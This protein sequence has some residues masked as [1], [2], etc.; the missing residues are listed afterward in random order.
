MRIIFELREIHSAAN[1][2]TEIHSIAN[3]LLTFA[4]KPLFNYICYLSENFTMKPKLYSDG[5]FTADL[6]R[7]KAIQKNYETK[8]LI[9]DFNSRAE[10]R[11]NPE[12]D[13][14]EMLEIAEF[15]VY[16]VPYAGSD[17]M[18]AYYDE[19]VEV[20]SEYLKRNC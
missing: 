2:L 20:W 9:F 7:I 1:S 18:N 12:T 13:E 16:T 8:Q 4:Q 17:Q 19:W 6:S 15:P 11:I 3:S 14:E 10:F 5:S